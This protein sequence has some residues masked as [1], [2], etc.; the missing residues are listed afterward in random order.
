MLT[1]RLKAVAD[2]VPLNV[3]LADIGTDHANLPIFLMNL[4]KITAAIAVDVREVLFP[5]PSQL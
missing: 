3:R 2:F 5:L 1:P 4:H